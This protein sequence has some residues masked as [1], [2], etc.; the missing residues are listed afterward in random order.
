[1]ANVKKGIESNLNYSIEQKHEFVAHVSDD[2]LRYETVKQ[3]LCAVSDLAAFFASSFG[4]ASLGELI[5]MAHD[6]GKFSKE[7]QTRILRNGPKVDHSTAGAYELRKYFA[8]LLSYC[9]AGHHG[10]LPNGG[11]AFDDSTS[12]MGRLNAASNGIIPDYSAFQNFVNL[13]EPTNPTFKVVSDSEEGRAFSLSFF[14]RMLYSCLVDADFLCTEEFMDEHS[15]QKSQ[16]D[17][18][19]VMRERLELYLERFF[20]PTS[21]VNKIR[22]KLLND[23]FDAAKGDVGVYSLTAPTGSGKTISLLRFALNH[24]CGGNKSM[25]RIICAIPY[26]S[27][28]EQNAHVY[29]DILGNTNVL[30][31]HSSFEPDLEDSDDFR[32]AMMLAT[33]NWDAPLV[34]T[35]NVQLF[36]SLFAS[37]P[38]RCRKLHNIANSVILLDEVQM[39]P[40]KYLLPCVKV[41]SELVKNYGCTVVLCTATQPCLNSFFEGEGLKVKEIVSDPISLSKSLSRVSYKSEGRLNDNELILM[42]KEHSQVLCIVNSRKQARELYKKMITIDDDEGLFHLTTSMHAHHRKQ[43]LSE[44]N[45]RLTLGKPCCVIATCLVEAGVD[46]DFP[47]VFRAVAGIDSL[48]QAAGR[49]NREGCRKKE[50]SIVHIFISDATYNLPSEVKQR[51]TVSQAV[52]PA[53]TIASDDCLAIENAVNSYFDALYVAKGSQELDSKNIVRRLSQNFYQ[54][55]IDSIVIIFPFADVGREFK[56]IDEETTSLII[57]CDENESVLNRAY[58][59]CASRDDWRLLSQYSVSLYPVDAKRLVDLGAVELLSEGVY[60]LLDQKLYSSNLGL[61]ITET[62]G[63]ALFF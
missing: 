2:G 39:L 19:G 1:M 47:V 57:P 60:I 26:T 21:E 9:V 4:A 61:V 59:G 53:L 50:E 18:I 45:R 13:S 12:L 6:I 5:G 30:E 54:Q 52:L 40:A 15:R 43:V 49:C 10:G 44:V 28:I 7:F 46:L 29:R 17:S 63:D 27:I 37:K 11:T 16:Y 31:H 22:C 34:I 24:A 23:C 62:G 51:A 35:T 14:T 56:F 55:R 48:V 3:H 42:L 58:G 38:S 36:E 25:Q 8:G 32:N 20:P 33:E 41:L